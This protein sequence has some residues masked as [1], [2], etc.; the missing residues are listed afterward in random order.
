M[1]LFN[2]SKEMLV[3]IYFLKFYT[4]NFI[5]DTVYNCKHFLALSP[6]L[7]FF[8]SKKKL[9]LSDQN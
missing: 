9:S 1:S 2:H 5:T 8:K 7:S 6:L 3:K 4:V